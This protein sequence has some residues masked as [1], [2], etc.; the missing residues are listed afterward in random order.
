M[1][2]YLYNPNYYPVGMF[3]DTYDGNG[4]PMQVYPLFRQDLA[5]P[6]GSGGTIARLDNFSNLVYTSLFD[7]TELTT[8]GGR[9]F[10]HKLAGAAGDE[11]SNNYV[12]VLAATGVKNYP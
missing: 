3:D 2:A 8:P 9:A 7:P 11:V 5:A 1:D 6:Y 12:K 4:D 10:L